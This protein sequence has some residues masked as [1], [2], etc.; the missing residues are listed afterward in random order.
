MS[1]ASISPDSILHGKRGKSPTKSRMKWKQT[2]NILFRDR[3]LY[4]LALPGILFFI[5]FKY[6]PMWGLVIAFQ[7]Y[8]PYAGILKSDWV[9]LEHFARFFGN[10]DFYLLLRNTLAISTL[11]ILLF[12][13][14]PIL[15]SIMLNEV[16]QMV[17]KRVVQTVIYFPYFLSWVIIAGLSFI[18]LGQSEGVVNAILVFLGFDKIA[19]LTSPG[20]FWIMLTLQTIWKDAGFGTVIFLA[21]IAGIDPTLYEAAKMDGASRLKQ[22]RHVT[23]PGIRN[24]II[25]L[26]ILRLGDVMDVGFEQVFLMGSAAVSNVSDVFDT[27]VYRNGIL[28]GE[29]S[30]TASVGLFKSFVGL[31]MVVAANKLAKMFGQDGLY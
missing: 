6:V 12:F 2:M 4:L 14:A 25:V 3:F 13:P 29:F 24:V 9:G 23:L 30:Y 7:N 19:F 20:L 15:F 1:K 16:R 18:M 27:Y 21:A 10:E 28:N 31:I 17:F 8:S 11:N 5:I 26:L 22:I